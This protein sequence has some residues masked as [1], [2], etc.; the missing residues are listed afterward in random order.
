V[1]GFIRTWRATSNGLEGVAALHCDSLLCLDEMGQVDSREGGH[2][3]YMLANGVGK[4]RA[5]RTGE[6]RPAA[7]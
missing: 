2:I 5:T 3:A 4:T 6:A 7:E 1:R